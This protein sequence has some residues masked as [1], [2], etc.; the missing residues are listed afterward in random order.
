M[1]AIGSMESEDEEEDLQPP[2]VPAKE[3]ELLPPPVTEILLPPPEQECTGFPGVCNEQPVEEPPKPQKTAGIALPI[4]EMT[5]DWMDDGQAIGSMDSEDEEEAAKF[6]E[7]PVEEPPKAQ[8]AAGIA[9]PI[10]EM[11]DDW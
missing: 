3:D 7:K 5:D 2:P 1:G 11:T 8:K 4:T 9:L 10:T 6:A